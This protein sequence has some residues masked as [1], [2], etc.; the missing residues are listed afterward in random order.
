MPDS[1]LN[2]IARHLQ[3]IYKENFTEQ[4][5]NEIYRILLPVTPF[6]GKE[7][8]L[9]NEND[10]I[11]ITY[12][13]SVISKNKNPLNAL[14][15]LLDEYIG[16]SIPCL[17][18]L[19]FF[20]YT[21]DDGFSVTD[22][23]SVNP[24]L[25]DWE[26]IKKIGK[27]YDLMID[28]VI[29]H[30]SKS[31]LWFK[32][33]LENKEPGRN[34]FIQPG[35]DDDLSFVIRPRSTPLLTEFKA[36]DGN[37]NVWTTFSDDQI[38]LN[39]R[40]P[41]VLIEILK[42]FLFYIRQGI[43]ILRLDAIAFLWKQPGTACMHLPENHEIVKILRTIGTYINPDLL[44]L[45]ETNVPHNENVSYFGQ[46]DEA[47]LVYQFSLPPLLLY[48]FFSGN[49]GY[50]NNWLSSLTDPPYNCTFLNFT[51]SH[52]GIG[53]RPLEGLL[54]EAYKEQLFN[55]MLDFGGRLSYRKNKDGTESV[56]EINITYFDALKGTTDGIDNQ[57]IERF[58]CSQVIM[59]SLKGIP[60]V[61]IHSLLATSNDYE[62]MQ[63]TG[64]LRSINRKK[65]LDSEIKTMLSENTINRYVF[66]E[67]KRIIDIRKKQSAFDPGSA[68]KIV[69]AGSNFISFRRININTHEDI[70]CISN[71]TNKIQE[72]CQTFN[73]LSDEYI[74]LLSEK[75]FIG[76]SQKISVRP[77]QTLWLKRIVK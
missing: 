56:Y 57:Q 39:F 36:V 49:A 32:N 27:D 73:Y 31:H 65:Y 16:K 69:E 40:N 23:M 10:I 6:K 22:Y 48:T 17:H 9:W 53:V 45:T 63:S 43:R 75:K 30:V 8:P 4:I 37:R 72:F 2:K 19:P 61:Y 50:F 59:L 46:G 41:E 44:L 77:Y 12:G 51:A 76:R 66:N 20:P 25:G 60:A 64:R 29:N 33:F 26:D 38:D 47:H 15:W 5:T 67:L 35:A 42:V 1:L 52:D 7:K 62:G 58:I 74:D 55:A 3:T 14:K 24:E 54:P 18:I 68:Q 11:M 28:L 21:S 71:I 70:L 34:F 13:N